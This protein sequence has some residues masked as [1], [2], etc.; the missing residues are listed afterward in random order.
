MNEADAPWPAWILGDKLDN[1]QHVEVERKKKQERFLV[2]H[3]FDRVY[4]RR[5][6]E[7]RIY[8]TLETCEASQTFPHFETALETG[9]YG[10]SY[11]SCLCYPAKRGTESHGPALNL[12]F[13]I[14]TD[15]T[16]LV[17]EWSSRHWISFGPSATRLLAFFPDLLYPAKEDHIPIWR[18]PVLRSVRD[19]LLYRVVA[20]EE[21]EGLQARWLRGSDEEWQ[22]VAT[23]LWSSG[24]LHAKDSHSR[25]AG[26]Y[27]SCWPGV[28]YDLKTP[29]LN[30]I[31]TPQLREFL[32]QSFVFRGL[33][34]Q[35]DVEWRR[36]K[37][38]RLFAQQPRIRCR[39]SQSVATRGVSFLKSETPSF[40]E[41]LEARLELR[42]WLLD[43][44]PREQIESWLGSSS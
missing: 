43:K 3:H 27:C 34:W 12:H 31:G 7:E 44:A 15:G 29:H 23:W 22:Q 30:W 41:Q 19:Q 18:Q 13:I 5:V 17:R 38:R 35:A 42:D 10:W 14:H 4:F 32:R 1:P 24:L 16:G 21:L 6:D 11:D 37:H 39:W 25:Y 28:P 36:R 33:D 8:S 20:P 9:N 40:H 2:Q 26:L